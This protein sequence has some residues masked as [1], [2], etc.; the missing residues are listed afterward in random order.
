MSYGFFVGLLEI[1]LL[2][3]SFRMT[4]PVITS[5]GHVYCKECLSEAVNSQEGNPCPACRYAY[6]N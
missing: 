3:M 6:L 2:K 1:R 5:C 4:N